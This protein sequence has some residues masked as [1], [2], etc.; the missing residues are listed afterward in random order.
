M[1]GIPD[2][3]HTMENSTQPST[4]QTSEQKHKSWLFRPGYAQGVFWITLVAL[5]SNM[6]DILMREASRLPA[7]EVTF[8]RY[9]FAV[10]TVLPFMLLKAKSS[11]KTKRPFVHVIRSALLFVAIFAWAGAVKV[12]PL[13]LMSLYALTVPLFVLP[14]AS[15]F[16]KERV[17]WQRTLATLLGFIGIFVTMVGSGSIPND[18]LS[19][20]QFPGSDSSPNTPLLTSATTTG[21]WLLL[22]SVMSFALSDIVN[23]KY[24][25]KES[26]LSMLFYIALGT[27]GL[28]AFFVPSVWISPTASE[29]AYLLCLGAGG[30]LILFFLLKAFAATD[31]SSLAPF[32]YTELI[33]AGI[34]GYIL[35]R[36]IPSMWTLSGGLII[37]IATASIAYYEI[38]VRRINSKKN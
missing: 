13:A 36:E 23:K 19:V 15:A 33:F 31:V 35:Y 37:I 2:R 34:F 28:S 17:G 20:L 22:G 24:V 18:V 30:N 6:N 16:L 8:F 11:F 12:V 25:S 26:D 7:Q 10:L 3:V 29:Y 5:T 38:N 32:R 4:E 14:M 9:A 27:A 1:T 21:T